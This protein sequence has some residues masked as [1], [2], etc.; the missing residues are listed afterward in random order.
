MGTQMHRRAQAPLRW[1]TK[2]FALAGIAAMSCGPADEAAAPSVA[3]VSQAV[4][5][6]YVGGAPIPTMPN[7][8]TLN[9]NGTY[10]ELIAADAMAE[11]TLLQAVGTQMGG[12]TDPDV[13]LQH[14]AQMMSTSLGVCTSPAQQAAPNGIS[15]TEAF[16][17]NWL[18]MRND[19]TCN[20]DVATQTHKGLG[21]SYALNGNGTYALPS[22]A[23]Y[24]DSS[25]GVTFGGSALSS[26]RQ[27][28][29]DHVQYAWMNL[30]MAQN[31]RAELD[32]S[33]V[34][35]ASE[36]DLRE[37]QGLV[38]TRALAAVYQ[39]TNILNAMSTAT[40]QTSIDSP[41]Y[42]G[43]IIARWKAKDT[44]WSQHATEL[45][46]DISSA[47][48]LLV[49][50]GHDVTDVLL[51]SSGTTQQFG[52]YQSTVGYIGPFQDAVLTGPRVEALMAGYGAYADAQPRAPVTSTGEP[53]VQ[54]LAGLVGQAGGIPLTGYVGSFNITSNATNLLWLATQ[55][56]AGCTPTA[57]C[58]KA[59][60]PGGQT[61]DV[62]QQKYNIQLKHAVALVR[63][64]L[65]HLYGQPQPK[66]YTDSGNWKYNFDS[67]NTLGGL[68]LDLESRVKGTHTY[69]SPS[70]GTVA[71][72]FTSASGG[73]LKLDPSV[74]VVA[75]DPNTLQSEAW[76]DVPQLG[77]DYRSDPV[78]NSG[79]DFRYR[80][81]MYLYYPE[82]INTV[83]TSSPPSGLPD[84]Q[85]KALH[86]LYR[87]GSYMGT[88]N[89]LS[90]LRYYFLRANAGAG[91]VIKAAGAPLLNLLKQAIGYRQVVVRRS[92]AVNRQSG[93]TSPS[94]TTFDNIQGTSALGSGL[95]VDVYVNQSRTDT[96]KILTVRLLNNPLS[97][98]QTVTV[99]PVTETIDS[100]ITSIATATTETLRKYTVAIPANAV[101]ELRLETMDGST[102]VTVFRGKLDEPNS[103]EP[104]IHDAVAG[105]NPS[106]FGRTVTFGGALNEQLN[107]AVEF[108]PNDWSK[109]AFDPLDFPNN[110]APVGDASL[111]GGTPG[112]ETYQYF[113][114]SA[115]TAAHDATTAV[116]K[117]LQTV[118][119]EA[120]DLLALEQADERGSTLDDLE[121]K[122]FCGAATS[123]I[124][125]NYIPTT[126]AVPPCPSGKPYCAQAT[127][128]FAEVIGATGSD[129]PN[130][131]PLAADVATQLDAVQPDFS[132]FSGGQLEP[133]LLAEWNAWYALRNAIQN[134][135]MTT[136]VQAAQID[137]ADAEWNQALLVRNQ[138][139]LEASTAATELKKQ[140]LDVTIQ[141]N[142]LAGELM[143]YD[144]QVDAAK[145]A[146]DF[147]C[148][149]N[150]FATAREAAI[151]FS[152]EYGDFKTGAQQNGQDASALNYFFDEASSMSFSVAP[153][154]Q[155]HT[156]CE[157]ARMAVQNAQ[158]M[159]DTT[160]QG[161]SINLGIIQSNI[162]N[163]TVPDS[164]IDAQLQATIEAAAAGYEAATKR[165]VET[166]AEAAAAVIAEW[167]TARQALNDVYTAGVALNAGLNQ[168]SVA[169]SKQQ[170]DTTLQ[171][172]DVKSRF[173]LKTA[174]H[175]Y[176][177]W[178]ARALSESARRLAVAARRAIEA[179]FVLNL[180]DLKE[181]ETFVEAPS[182]WADE[183]YN[184]DLKP[185]SSLGRTLGPTNMNPTAVYS[186]AIEDYVNNLQLFVNGY[187]ISRPTA[188]AHS[189]TE[190]LELPGPGGTTEVALWDNVQF[191]VRN[192]EN[193]VWSFYCARGGSWTG[194]NFAATSF[195]QGIQDLTH[196]C[197]GAD[198]DHHEAPTRARMS[199]YLSPLGALNGAREL[200]LT[201]ARHNA[202]WRQ[203]AI[204]LVGTGVRDCSQDVDPSSC[205]QEPFIRYQLRH[206][207]PAEVSDFEDK[208]HVLQLPVGNIENG[209][210]LAAEE[211]V[212]PVSKGFDNSLVANVARQEF[213]GRPLGGKYELTVEA[214]AGV[215]LENIERVQV[216]MQTDYWVRQQ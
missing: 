169:T 54:I 42:F 16:Y 209:K 79:F 8:T 160:A 140:N 158:K 17:W 61:F 99:S 178:R 156:N 143:S 201:T 49:E 127:T 173:N 64:L 84:A 130:P 101:V 204:N 113:L 35:L 4:A 174:F 47:T 141:Y 95:N 62:I 166:K 103:Y 164:M 193:G 149:A 83:Y 185:P 200:D 131:I 59:L 85:I 66:F 27:V 24:Q 105:Q 53:E 207:G 111:N 151:S 123:C 32:S 187:S 163:I 69:L 186:S 87:W 177:M 9:W 171:M 198:S 199:F 170:L 192:T 11:C 120:S 98:A 122:S 46:Q 41:A 107:R 10:P 208:W 210:A 147:A 188:V 167:G 211:W 117:A 181:P 3:Q 73:T 7:A 216:L 125:L 34:A 202:R 214:P 52:T 30:C 206:V 82:Q 116:D 12:T 44:N 126:I 51:R 40:V 189:D 43:S 36:N 205:Y 129:K 71:G 50:A 153:L 175:S 72:D 124:P 96:L 22:L 70:G 37:L 76:S 91:D 38:R 195:E 80:T 33:E 142:N 25:G 194:D 191:S 106:T 148:S 118:T 183:I 215:R 77:F 100:S 2:I 162:D 20:L 21:L 136:D 29:Q 154:A 28:A 161:I 57:T 48:N 39:Y 155:F 26:A 196:L 159:D 93:C 115:T 65:E 145:N 63:A 168:A 121:T 132:R 55:I 58:W 128:F 75:P 112:Q 90:Y 190:V 157:Q 92:K 172:Q 197:P 108:G 213:A 110:W 139:E 176:D 89:V 203:L 88:V 179:R 138:A 133:L 67:Q 1:T 137:A 212:D 146:A 94:C 74:L 150:A 18:Q 86:S 56:D 165:D 184:S 134:M 180:S 5:T 45:G 182:L 60:I 68:P 119:D 6:A 109:P 135:V 78:A 14:L 144:N 23:T 15:S 19:A 114:S 13:F 81:G 102:G 31:I 97:V 104:N 152:G